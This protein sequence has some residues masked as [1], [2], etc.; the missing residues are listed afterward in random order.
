MTKLPVEFAP[1]QIA[2]G[3]LH[4]DLTELIR[5]HHKNGLLIQAALYDAITLQL[6]FLTL[7][8]VLI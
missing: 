5:Y 4:F 1:A 8:K 3:H 2:D 7:K 6:K